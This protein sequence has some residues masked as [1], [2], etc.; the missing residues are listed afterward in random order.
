MF[1][2]VVKKIIPHWLFQAVEPT[3]HLFEAM[4]WQVVM[5]FPAKGLKVI[6]VTGTNGKTTVSFMAHTMLN[7]AGYKVGLMST[8]GYGAGSNIHP[9]VTHMTTSSTR[10]TLKRIRE[11]RKEGIEWLVLETTSHAL[12]QN[13]VWG[14]PYSVAVMTNLTHEHLAYHRTFE[15]Y[16]EAKVKLFRLAAAGSGL[17]IGVL[18]A[19]DPNAPYF[20]AVVPN[21]IRYSIKQ[22]GADLVAS[23]VKSSASGNEFDVRYQERRLRITTPLPGSFNVYNSMAA[24][25]VGIA[26]G[27][28]DKQIENGIAALKS[29]EGRMARIEEGQDFSVIVDYAHS[30]DSFEKLFTDMKVLSKGRMIVVFGSQGNT[31]DVSKR[32]IQGRL[33]GKHADLVVITE[34]DDRGEDGQAIMEQIAEGARQSGKVADRDMWLIHNRSD[35]IAYGIGLARHNDVVMLLGKGHE[36]TIEHNAEGEEPW[37]EPGEARRALRKLKGKRVA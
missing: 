8:V 7:E 30:P 34:E 6:G 3:G 37:D 28:S 9:Q 21:V 11:L 2:K 14:I 31:G 36:K 19:D 35:A 26:V 10:V 16:R 29:V 17:R 33:A 32:A 23:N 25:G 22:V 18:N 20:A 13:R 5:G 24:C 1:R 15:R 12:A 27:L 4:M